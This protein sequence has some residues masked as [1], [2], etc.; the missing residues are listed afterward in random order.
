MEP[1]VVLEGVAAPLD[2]SKVDTDQ[3]LPARFLRRPRKEGY[4]QFLFKDS[5]DNPAFVLNQAPYRAAKILVAD[6][7]FGVG[8]S[9]EQAPWALSDYGI[10]CVIAV[11]FG[12]IFVLN[13]FKAGVLPIALDSCDVLRKQL[14]AKPGATMQIDLPSQTV[15]GPDG[16][17]YRFDIDPFRK[18]C[19]LEGLDEIGV[20]LQNDAAIAAF[21]KRYRQRFDWLFDG[22]I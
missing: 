13:S 5:M 11:D 12:E 21:E 17:T 15:T 7:A 10:R 3:I 4:G 1:F 14:H 19:L 18:K 20:T 2:Q 9:R 16:S 8:S 22:K 6:R